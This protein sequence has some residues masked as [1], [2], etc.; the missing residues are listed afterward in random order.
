MHPFGVVPDILPTKQPFWDRPGVLEDKALVEPSLTSTHLWT[1]FLAASTQHS[2]HWLFV[3]PI[4][5]CS[6]RLD[7]DA[8]RVAVGFRL[9]LNLSEPHQG[10]YG[11]LVDARGLQS[12]R[13]HAVNDLIA[14]SFASAGVPV[15]KEPS[16]LFRTD[17]KR[18][19]G[20][21]LVPWQSGTSMCWDVTV[22]CPLA[23]LYVKGAATEAGAL[24]SRKEANYADLE[25][26]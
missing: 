11:L 10:H 25:S 19:H 22:I 26:R 3:M 14:L 24:A 15:T 4:A 5:S 6:L 1:S 23:E 17:G 13:H 20:P 9:G 2:G 18:P 16:R 8:V 7:N 12:A 21:T